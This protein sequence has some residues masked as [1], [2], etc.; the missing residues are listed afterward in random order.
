MLARIALG[1]LLVCTL[2]VII[3]TPNTPHL[4]FT[5]LYASAGFIA[6]LIAHS[7]WKT[8]REDALKGVLLLTVAT[9]VVLLGFFSLVFLALKD[10]PDNKIRD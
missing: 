9:L 4:W 10:P 5:V 1:T 6:F 7:T 2:A 3:V 8:D